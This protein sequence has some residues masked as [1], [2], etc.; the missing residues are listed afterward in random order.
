M[1]LYYRYHGAVGGAVDV[2]ARGIVRPRRIVMNVEEPSAVVGAETGR[3]SLLVDNCVNSCFLIGIEP[4]LTPEVG[5]IWLCSIRFWLWFFFVVHV[6]NID[7]NWLLMICLQSV[8][9]Q[10]DCNTSMLELMSQNH[11]CKTA[12]ETNQWWSSTLH[13]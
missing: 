2:S 12:K 1:Q 3:H 13:C 7:S 4:R 11:C 5:S 10:R 8:A 6:T 9:L